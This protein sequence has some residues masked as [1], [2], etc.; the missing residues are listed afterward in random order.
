MGNCLC[1]RFIRSK[2][3]DPA[4]ETGDFRPSPNKKDCFFG[5]CPSIARFL[6][7]DQPR[8]GVPGRGNNADSIGIKNCR[9]C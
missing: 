2:R 5:T 8:N 9:S 1:F 3:D 6:Q 7:R 4:K